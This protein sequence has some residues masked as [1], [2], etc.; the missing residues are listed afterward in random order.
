MVKHR[1]QKLKEEI[2]KCDVRCANCHR[3]KT[4]KER[5]FYKG[6]VL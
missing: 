3:I 5:G 2:L 1:F 6:I 4:A